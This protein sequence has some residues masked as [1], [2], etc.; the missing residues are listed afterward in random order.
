M[1]SHYSSWLPYFS[2]KIR[3]LIQ[4][5]TFPLS[6]DARKSFELIKSD[7]AGALIDHI[8]ENRPFVVETD[9]SDFCIAATLS[10]NNKPVVFFFK[11]AQ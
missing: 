5:T 10:Q 4:S 9:A 3:P 2:K 8:D 1:F 11:N 6:T 7:I